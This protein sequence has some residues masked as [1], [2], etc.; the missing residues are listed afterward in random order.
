MK[1]FNNSFDVVG[2]K[3]YELALKKAIKYALKN[4]D[5]YKRKLK[6]FKNMKFNIKEFE[7]IPFTTKKD[8]LDDQ[9]KYSPF[10]S[11][12]SVDISKIQRVHR[13]SGTTDRPLILALTK[14]D[15]KLMTETGS[16]CSKISGLKKKDVVVHCLN[17]CMWMGGLTDHMS[18]EKSGAAV[19]PYGVGNS[20]QL[21]ETILKQNA[22][23]SS[24]LLSNG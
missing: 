2:K 10:G 6:S 7:K 8:L 13:T 23:V 3:N 24:V 9:K 16:V 20:K 19:V 12:L 4:S 15:V 1:I 11:N 21:I 5:F 14:N 22:G 18:L 17:Y